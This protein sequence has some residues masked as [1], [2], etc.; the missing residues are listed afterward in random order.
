MTLDG[1]WRNGAGRTGAMGATPDGP[2]GASR[3]ELPLTHLPSY[4]YNQSKVLSTGAVL[5][6]VYIWSQDS[7]VTKIRLI[8]ARKATHAEIGQYLEAYE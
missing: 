4:N 7:N 5:S 2:Q 1:E 6:V 3:R 8:S